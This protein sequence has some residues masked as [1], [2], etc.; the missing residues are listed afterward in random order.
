MA[1]SGLWLTQID[2][3]AGNALIPS[4]TQ[5]LMVIDHVQPVSRLYTLLCVVLFNS[6]CF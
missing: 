5:E 6:C 3:H 1:N 4:E 2:L